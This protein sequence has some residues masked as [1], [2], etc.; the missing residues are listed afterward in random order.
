MLESTS[1]YEQAFFSQMSP[2]SFTCV[3]GEIGLSNG[4]KRQKVKSS[5]P[6]FM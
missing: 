1:W 4:H 5:F 3:L 6:V 2:V